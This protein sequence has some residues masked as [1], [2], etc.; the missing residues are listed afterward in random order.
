MNGN[1]LKLY[2]VLQ[3][4]FL[5]GLS[6]LLIPNLKPTQHSKTWEINDPLLEE[7]WYLEGQPVFG[8]NVVPAWKKY[9][10]GTGII[11]GVVDTGI[12]KMNDDLKNKVK[13]KCPEEKLLYQHGTQVAGLM[14]AEANNS[15]LGTGVAFGAMLADLAYVKAGQNI[16]IADD[17]LNVTK[18]NDTIDIFSC[19]FSRGINGESIYKIP[20]SLRQNL[21]KGATVGRSG[22]GSLYVVSSGNG[23]QFFF[24]ESCAYDEF[25][26]N[27]NAILVAGIDHNLGTI[28]TGEKCSAIMVTAPTRNLGF[29]SFPTMVTTFGSN[30]TNNFGLTSAAVAITSGAIAVMLSART[31]LT[32]R[33]VM[34]I[35]A[36]TT[37]NNVT[38]QFKATDTPFECNGA[39]FE[40]SLQ[41][42]FGLLDVQAMVEEAVK[43]ESV[44]RKLL[45]VSEFQYKSLPIHGYRW[46]TE[47]TVN[48]TCQIAYLEHVEVTIVIIDDEA[49][50]VTAELKSPLL[51]SSTILQ[52]RP[53]YGS[54]SI[55]ITVGCVQFWGT[56]PHGK[57]NLTLSN[58]YQQFNGKIED[59]HITFH[60]IEKRP[61]NKMRKSCTLDQRPTRAVSETNGKTRTT[62]SNTEIQSHSLTSLAITGIAIACTVV[63]G[64][65]VIIIILL[66]KRAM[67]RQLLIASEMKDITYMQK[68]NSC[69]NLLSPVAMS[70]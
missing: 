4:W 5:T 42:G 57:W 22:K 62:R 6:F 56:N 49:E 14:A 16:P 40:V 35:L 47:F 9:Y 38:F 51:F 19:S 55:N 31:N 53:L 39:G 43:W 66:H 18:W 52:G 59:I 41:Y 26:N 64:A 65:A 1:S 33:D 8:I 58:K 44:G 27:I 30:Y 3:L 61:T 10:N 36:R 45:C 70:D 46:F 24:P 2:L 7:Q 20:C 67:K 48:S 63:V 54:K 15:F 21:Q 28:P 11:I 37:H 32:N 17:A 12:D 50:S 69:R 23:G 13:W 60:G 25:K 68:T 29:D 34:H